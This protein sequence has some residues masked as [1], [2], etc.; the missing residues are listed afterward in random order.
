[1]QVYKIQNAGETQC[2]CCAVDPDVERPD[3]QLSNPIALWQRTLLRLSAT[4]VELGCGK[5]LISEANRKYVE[6]KFSPPSARPMHCLRLTET[7]FQ[8]L[9]G[10]QALC[11]TFALGKISARTIGKSH[12]NEKKVTFVYSLHQ[13]FD[14]SV[15]NF[16]VFVLSDP[17]FGVYPHESSCRTMTLENQLFLQTERF[18]VFLYVYGQC[19]AYCDCCENNNINT[20]TTTNNTA[21]HSVLSY[22]GVNTV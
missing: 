21:G 12:W 1:M 4:H 5:S 10:I 17:A 16:S 11:R 3:K 18:T 20:N 15:L 19:V 6:V 13:I 22:S 7:L 8:H 9:S 14:Y 2:F